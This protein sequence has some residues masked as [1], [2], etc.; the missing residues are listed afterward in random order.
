MKTGLE[1]YVHWERD[2][3]SFLEDM[4]S[5]ALSQGEAAIAIKIKE[6]IKSV[7]K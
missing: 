4:Y 2:T 1:K 3:K 6:Y 7:D 5:Q